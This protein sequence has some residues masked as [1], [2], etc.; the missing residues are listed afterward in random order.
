[1]K[2]AILLAAG[3]SRRFGSN[4]MLYKVLDEELGEDLM[5]R[6]AARKFLS[7][8]VFDEVVV[9]V[10]YEYGKVVEALAD[11]DVKFVFNPDFTLG[12]STSVIA[13]VRRVLKH[14]ELVAIHPSDVPFVK[15]ETLRYL[16]TS[17]SSLCSG[18]CI[19]IPRYR[20]KGGHPLIILGNVVRE[21]LE[22]SERE[23]G[24][25][26]L[27]S[28][29]RELVRYLEVDDPGVVFDIDTPE[30]LQRAV[31]PVSSNFTRGSA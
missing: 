13:G 6:V 9:V 10:G 17:V 4:K 31:L 5:V 28:K 27:I 18:D 24:L 21:V 16:A 14:S 1:M 22:I 2:S 3:E 29:N 30:D 25:K 15:T 19:V 20:S 23:R 26:G 12:M 11:L 7:S 8:S